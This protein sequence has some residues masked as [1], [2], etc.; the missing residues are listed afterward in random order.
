MFRCVKNSNA[1]GILTR[2]IC[3]QKKFWVADRKMPSSKMGKCNFP[4]SD[5]LLVQFGQILPVLDHLLVQ[6]GQFYLF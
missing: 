1:L 4:V 2:R 5:Q 3:T 6:Y